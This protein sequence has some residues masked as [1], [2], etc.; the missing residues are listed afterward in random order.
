MHKILCASNPAE[1]AVTGD[2]SIPQFIGDDEPLRLE[3]AAARAFPDGSMTAAG[4][5]REHRRGRLII[6]RVAGKDYTTLRAIK[7]MREK[8][9]NKVGERVYGSNLQADARPQIGL[10]GTAGSNDTLAAVNMK[11]K[12]LSES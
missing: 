6:E 4:L 2:A 7:E 5:R 9:R 3:I 10:S 12:K 1:G 8:C 11:L